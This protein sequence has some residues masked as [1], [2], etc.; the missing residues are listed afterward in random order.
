MK[1]DASTDD[2]RMRVIAEALPQIV[3]TARPDGWIDYFNKRWFEYTGYTFEETQGWDWKPVLH[4]D[5]F[6][7]TVHAWTNSLRSGEALEIEYRLKRFDGSYRWHIGRALPVQNSDGEITKWFGTCTDVQALKDQELELE[8]LV[9]RRTSELQIALDQSLITNRINSEFVATISH[10]VR[11]PMAGVIGLAD[12]LVQQPELDEQTREIAGEIFKASNRLLTILNGILD[13]SKN[14]SR[15]NIVNLTEFSIKT[16]VETVINE[17]RILTAKK[18]L[19][20][21]HK[22]S[23]AVPDLVTGDYHR[24]TQVLINLL[25]NAIKFTE[26]GAVTLSIESVKETD[27]DFIG[28]FTISDTGIGISKEEQELLFKPFSQADNTIENRFG[29][30]GLGLSIC[31]NYVELMGG[32]I[33]VE[34][35]ADEGASF[36]FS[37]P[38]IKQHA[39]GDSPQACNQLLR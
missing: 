11:T 27:K 32:D 16:L 9:R 24:L 39:P 19:K 10:E 35:C 28:K 20:M 25:N 5:D 2:I 34:S 23:E 33:G 13:F 38:L 21:N 31:K 17:T 4:P 30:T 36:W 7:R 14:E 29:G 6:E 37:V 12:V 1:K 8:E 18:R 26:T 3:W 15:R 22:I